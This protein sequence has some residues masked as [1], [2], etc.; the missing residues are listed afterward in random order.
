[1]EGGHTCSAPYAATRD[2]PDNVVIV[3]RETPVAA[4]E[5]DRITPGILVVEAILV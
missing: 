2:E 1:M 3:E 4:I 5:E